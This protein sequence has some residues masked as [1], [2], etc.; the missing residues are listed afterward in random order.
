MARNKQWK[1]IQVDWQ[2]LQGFSDDDEDYAYYKL[3]PRQAAFC[4]T[5]LDFGMWATRWVN[6]GDTMDNIRK[7]VSKTSLNLMIDNAIMINCDEVDD[8]LETSEIIEGMDIVILANTA[9]SSTNS[10]DIQDMEENPPDGNLYDP[11]IPPSQTDLACQVAGYIANQLYTFIA[12]V[13]TYGTQP[14]MLTALFAAL[15]GEYLYSV[16]ILTNVLTNFI[17]GGA[18]PLAPDYDPQIEAL[19]EYMYCNNDFDK[20]SVAS[21]ASANLTRGS[22]IADEILCISLS[23]WQQWQM[24]GEFATGHVCTGFAC[25][26][27]CYYFDY[28]LGNHGYIGLPFGTSSSAKLWVNG[29]GQKAVDTGAD[30]TMLGEQVFTLSTITKIQ[31]KAYL[32]AGVVNSNITLYGRLDNDTTPVLATNGAP[33]Q[34]TVYTLDWNGNEQFKGVPTWL[35]KSQNPEFYLQEM[36]VWG[37]GASPFAPDNC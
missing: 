34:N 3:T 13:D 22:E 10:N 16:D 1:A 6:L 14:D 19:A 37:E 21:W 26:T 25:G 32:G 33:T 23:A 20:D 2:T 18:L 5:W 9:S 24:L 28:K 7:F 4:Q 30:Y 36:T 35:A 15:N 29:L 27:W 11:V 31:I 8:C 17:I 12:E